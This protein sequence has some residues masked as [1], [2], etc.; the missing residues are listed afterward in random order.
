MILANEATYYKNSEKIITQG[1]TE[2]NIQ[3]KYLIT[4]KNLTYLYDKKIL[5]SQNKTKLQD[6]KSQVYFADRFNYSIDEEIIK[7]QNILVITNYNLPKSDKFFLDDASIN[8]KENK[9]I[10]KKTKIEVH[11]DV[12]NNSENDPRIMGESSS[13]SK[14]FTIINKGVFTS[15]KRNDDCPP[16][17]IESELIKHDKIQKIIN[18]EN[19]VLK[20]YDFPVFYFPKFFHPDPSVKRQ[21]GLIKPA[22]NNSNILGTSVSLPYFKVIS[23]S[24][25]FTFTPT[26]FEKDTFMSTIEYRQKNQNSSL[27][28]DFGFVSGY[29]S[30]TSNKK[31]SLSHLFFDYDLDLQ[32]EKYNSSNLKTSFTQ[33][34]NDAYLNIFDQYITKS[35]LRPNDFNKLI[36]EIKLS[37][38]HENYNFQA[39]F[40]S[41]ENLQIKKQSDRYQYVLPYYNFDRQISQNYFNGSLFFNSNGNNVLDSTNK[42]ETNIINNLT[43]NS[44][45]YVSKLGLKN[46]FGVTIKNLNSIG[47]KTSKYKSS[48]QIELVSLYNA[49][50]SFPLIKA[51]KNTKNFLTPKLSFRFNPDNMK[52]YT[53]SERIIDAHNAFAINR[54]GLTD[55]LESGKSVTLGLDFKKERKINLEQINNYFE[56]KLATIIRDREEKSI[57]AKSTINKKNSNLFG[58]ITNKFSE[59]MKLTYNFSLDNDFNTLEYN[60]INTTFSI[61]N[62][63]SEFNFIEENGDRGDSN[64]F[65]SSISYGLDD[66]NFLSFETRRNRKLNLTEF[67]DLVYEYKND[68]L[69][70]GIKYNKTYYSN[71]DLKPTENL[72][73]TVTLFPLTIYEHDV[74]D[75][76]IN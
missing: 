25:D 3:S 28:A 29:K 72:L 9:F 50:I 33:V 2:A 30:S 60:N 31:N 67:Y 16:W 65:A 19:A 24:K 42:V 76:L 5:S 56:L 12:F 13:G 55:T 11:K 68:C 47:K 52:N 21:S 8:L 51:T 69:T 53:A 14:E 45:D 59:N 15:C 57:P 4:S 6:Q 26:I 39:G 34:S 46:N 74:K 7:G 18:Y 71:G 41:F 48:P 38:D 1:K 36:N 22:I 66:N 63:I 64:I 58:S 54:L 35:N 10:A 49:D 23:E 62:V 32:L 17:S 43:Y 70:A 40:Q 61:N 20:I 27:I 73:F 75:L 37:L 44:L